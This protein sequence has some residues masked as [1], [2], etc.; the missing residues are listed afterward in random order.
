[1]IAAVNWSSFDSDASR[2]IEKRMIQYYLNIAFI[3]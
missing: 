2:Q 3:L 1:M